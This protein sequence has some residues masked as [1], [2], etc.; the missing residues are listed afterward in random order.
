MIADAVQNKEKTLKKKTS[1]SEAAA[2]WAALC[3]P[4]RLLAEIGRLYYKARCV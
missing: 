1:F 4:I 2:E 3:L